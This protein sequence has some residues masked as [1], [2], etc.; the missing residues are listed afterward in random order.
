MFKQLFNEKKAAQVAAFFLMRASSALPVLKLMKLMY[1]AERGSFEAYGEGISGDRLVSM[2]HGPVM[3]ITLD[4]MNGS[5][6]SS[7]DGWDAWIAD[8]ANH[9]ISLT[10]SKRSTR[11]D[12]LLALSDAD[13]AI[14][15]QTWQKFGRLSKFQLVDYTHAH[16][17]EWQDPDGSMIPM[18]PMDFFKALGFSPEQSE[19]YLARMQEQ[20]AINAAFAQPL[21]A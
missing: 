8:R 16:C 15:E 17:P 14:L 12:D 7:P 11:A 5:K 10:D 6:E 2:Q 3:S 20:A 21:A 19:A 18:Q 9:E 1:L 13:L 4:L